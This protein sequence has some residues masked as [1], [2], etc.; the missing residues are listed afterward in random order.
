MRLERGS[1]A[2]GG[3][4]EAT[5]GRKERGGSSVELMKFQP[6]SASETTFWLGGSLT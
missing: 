3:I 5:E 6:S 2:D 4:V 1:L